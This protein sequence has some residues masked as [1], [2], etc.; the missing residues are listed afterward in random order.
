VKVLI[1]GGTG[2]FGSRLARLLVR[3]GHA[4]TITGR[5]ET[6][7]TT[8]ASEIGCHWLIFE[9]GTS[10]APLFADCPDVVVDAAGPF[11]AYQGD[12][13][14]LPRACAVHQT[15]YLDLSDDASFTARITDLDKDFRKAG[16][17]ALSGAS[18]VPA[19]SSSA[20]AFLAKE[21]ESID[22]IETTIMPGNRAPRGRSV[23][24]SILA[25]VGQPMRSW[26]GGMWREGRCWSNPKRYELFPGDWRIARTIRVP[27]LELFPVF[28]SAASVT[29]RAAME[30]RLLNASISFMALLSRHVSSALPVR[31]AA[32]SEWMAERLERFGTDTGGM[33]VDVTGTAGGRAI[34]RRWTLRVAAGD[35]PFIPCIPVR[36]LLRQSAMIKSGA[37]ACLAEFTIREAETAMDDLA[38]RFE[39]DGA[40]RPTLFQS[41][42]GAAWQNLPPEVQRLHSVQDIESFSG[43]AEVMRGTSLLARLTAMIFRFPAAGRNVPLTI[44]K[45]RTRSGETWERNF[46]G[47]RFR[48]YLTPARPGHY[49]ER[50][51]PFNYEQELPVVN[52]EMWLPVRRGWFLGIPLLRFMLPGSDSREYAENGQFHFDVGLS[53][54]LG[55]GLIVRYRGTVASDAAAARSR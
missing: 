45:T 7:L 12:V 27:D 18:S 41:A 26:R 14:G 23:I 1:V 20:V 55:G 13:F 40:D 10:F 3:D 50:F 35:G 9:R 25:Q 34:R 2:V 32:I 42:L 39:T 5:K 29:F 8:L 21:M 49:R 4:V 38:I 53:A 30:L 52:G 33:L 43:T 36:T 11:H 22:L 19:L 6:A 24:E 37:R 47:R 17:F 48:S 16:C 46:A 44:T 15:S 28:F 51:G 31:L 54:P